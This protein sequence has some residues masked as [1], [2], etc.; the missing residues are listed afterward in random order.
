MA[1]W[2]WRRGSGSSLA[3]CRL[4]QCDHEDATGLGMDVQDKVD[5]FF[6]R[7]YLEGMYM[8]SYSHT[9]LHVKCD[10]GGQLNLFSWCSDTISIVTSTKVKQFKMIIRWLRHVN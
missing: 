3:A 2:S 4:Q 6:S 9:T 7:S 8:P 1:N 10:K 5:E